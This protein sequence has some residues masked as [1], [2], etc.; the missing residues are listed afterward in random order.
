MRGGERGK[1]KAVSGD[2]PIHSEGVETY[3]EGKF[4]DALDEVTEAMVE[5]ASSVSPSELNEKAYALYEK[6]RPE[7]PSGKKGGT[8]WGTRVKFI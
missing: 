2:T 3:L 8:L 1:M 4:G 6:F 7:V 5:L